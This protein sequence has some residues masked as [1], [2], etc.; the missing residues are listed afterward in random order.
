MRSY[1]LQVCPQPYNYCPFPDTSK[2]KYFLKLL[3]TKLFVLAQ[4]LGLLAE[5][6]HL[7]VH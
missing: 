5:G 7:L 6:R 3:F 4:A 1:T 2:R